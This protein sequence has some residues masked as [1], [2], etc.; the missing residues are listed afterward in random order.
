MDP[1]DA[2][3]KSKLGQLTFRQSD[4][5]EID[6]DHC[7]TDV[8]ERDAHTKSRRRDKLFSSV[9]KK[10][11]PWTNIGAVSFSPKLFTSCKYPRLG[12]NDIRVLDLLR[13]GPDICRRNPSHPEGHLRRPWPQPASHRKFTRSAKAD[14]SEYG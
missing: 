4:D 10:E 3:L 11:S 5:D 1:Q 8:S 13:M 12:T 9:W 2:Q 6:F 7:E 14:L